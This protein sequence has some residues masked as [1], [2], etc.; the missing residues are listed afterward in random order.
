[1]S[2]LVTDISHKKQITVTTSYIVTTYSHDHI[3]ETK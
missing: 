1:M 3:I 2:V